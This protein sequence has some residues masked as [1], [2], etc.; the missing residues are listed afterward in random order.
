[1]RRIHLFEFEDLE[2]LPRVWRDT[3][4]DFLQFFMSKTV[5]YRPVVPKLKQVLQ[6][7]DC[8]RVIDL[9]SGAGGPWLDIGRQLEVEENYPVAVTLTD[10]YPNREAFRR[11]SNV[12]NG[13]ISHVEYPVDATDV[14]SHLKGFRTLFAGFHHLKPGAA[15]KV[16]QDAVEDGEGIGIFEIT[17]RSARVLAPTPLLVPLLFAFVWL[18]TPFLRPFKWTR[19]VWTYVVPV[20]PIFFIWDATISNLRTYS[21]EEVKKLI[22]ELG[23]E[24]YAWEF[25]RFRSR[26]VPTVTYV[27]GYPTRS[28]AAVRQA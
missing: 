7:L 25:G 13:S 10:K 11:A 2:W 1:M 9:C 21:F 12:S 22:E 24:G 18:A 15:K 3:M 4:T 26:V 27:L 17:E 6:K 23:C 14:P 5:P 20:I 28:S 16:L 19:L 8:P